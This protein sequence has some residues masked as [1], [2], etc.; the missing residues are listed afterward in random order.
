M[1]QTLITDEMKAAVGRT[2]RLATS[3]PIDASDIRRWAMAI[4][5]PA[6]PPPLYWDEDYAQTTR[7]GGI[8]APEEFNPFA[9][10]R[11]SPRLAET[12]P[13]LWPE[14]HLGIEPPPTCANILIEIGAN[15][16]GVRMRVGDVIRSEL[17]LKRYSERVG[18][19]GLMLSTET[20][21][22]W[23]NQNDE[24][25]RT[26]TQTFIRYG[27]RDEALFARY[28]GRSTA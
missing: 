24:L 14:P 19:L 4:Y 18:R 11:V 13:D 25:V 2:Y 28:A 3:Y 7:W 22:R 1:E 23:F 17:S 27:S 21:D 15:H 6:L 9:W 10:M 8:V 5:F 16:S 12:F 26:F 20:E